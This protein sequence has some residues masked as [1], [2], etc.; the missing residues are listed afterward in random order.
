[1]L[2]R[3]VFTNL[4][5]WYVEIRLKPLIN[6]SVSNSIIIDGSILPNDEYEQ[7][8]KVEFPQQESDLVARISAYLVYDDGDRKQLNFL[9]PSTWVKGDDNFYY[10]Q[11]LTKGGEIANFSRKIVIPD[12]HL[13]S[14]KLY[15]IMINIETIAYNEEIIETIWS[16]SPQEIRDNWNNSFNNI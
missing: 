4:V 11:S 10:Y 6:A 1:M 5:S 14:K 8:I 3:I 15:S 7:I 9:T 12:I 13:K 2:S 16:T